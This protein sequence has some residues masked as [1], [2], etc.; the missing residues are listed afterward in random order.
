MK[1]IFLK[2]EIVKLCCEVTKKNMLESIDTLFSSYFRK[3]MKWAKD[4]DI[5]FLRELNYS[6][7]NHGT[8]NMVVRREGTIGRE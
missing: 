7:L 6:Y 1:E 2:K 4:H 5:I 8:T 3:R